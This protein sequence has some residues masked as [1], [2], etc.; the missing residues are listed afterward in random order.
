MVPFLHVSLRMRVRGFMDIST[1]LLD[2]A[3]SRGIVG[4]VCVCVD[5]NVVHVRQNIQGLS[6]VVNSQNSQRVSGL[7]E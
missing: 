4:C 6:E 1:V 3:V 5:V 7:R 2:G